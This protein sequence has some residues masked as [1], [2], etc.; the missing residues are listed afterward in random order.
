MILAIDEGYSLFGLMNLYIFAENIHELL[1]QADTKLNYLKLFNTQLVDIK[2][3]NEFRSTT[4]EK[5]LSLIR[6]I[7]HILKIQNLRKE[8]SHDNSEGKLY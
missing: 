8:K 7:E 3:N 6:D 2:E 4:K 1:T 5:L